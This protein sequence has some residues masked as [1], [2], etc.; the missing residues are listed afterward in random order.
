MPLVRASRLSKVFACGNL[1][2]AGK[3]C[4]R[5]EDVS[6]DIEAGETL[7]LVGESGSGKSTLGRMVVG[8]AATRARAMSTVAGHAVG[9]LRG[10]ERQ[11]AVATGA[12]GVPGP[13]F[14]ARS[15]HDGA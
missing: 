6:F 12:D 8:P 15:P 11:G 10:A 3:P 5:C 2:S 14:V 13:I 4:T 1:C 7:G 9:A